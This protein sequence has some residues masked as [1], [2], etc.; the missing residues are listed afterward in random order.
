MKVLR[1]VCL[2]ENKGLS[3]YIPQLVTR[4][5]VLPFV[6]DPCV[7][8]LW[9]NIDARIAKLGPKNKKENL[10]QYKKRFRN[11]AKSK[12]KVLLRKAAAH[13]EPRIKAFYDVEGDHIKVY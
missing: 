7:S 3:K 1:E 8:L 5:H 2:L 6:C 13:M 9:D 10:E 11:T 12:S 4:M